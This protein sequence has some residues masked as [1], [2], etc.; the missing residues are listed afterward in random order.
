MNLERTPSTLVSYPRWLRGWSAL[1]VGVS[2]AAIV[3]GT[4]V[5][6]F[7]VGMA[8]TVWPTPPWYLLFHLRAADFGYYVE[9][10]HR[11]VAFL[12]ALFVFVQSLGFWNQCSDWTRRILAQLSLI[13]MAI[14]LG[15][16]MRLVRAQ[17][18]SVAAL[19]NYGL[20]IL[21]IGAL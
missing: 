8:D 19:V 6:T 21:A 1:T 15:E 4:L 17:E 5:T 7:G 3:V 2:F 20:V 9:H 10:T 11:I 18:R 12:A 13:L 14:G 16:W